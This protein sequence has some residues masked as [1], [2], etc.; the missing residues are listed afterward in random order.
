MEDETDTYSE[1]S[2]SWSSSPS[3]HETK[4][5]CERLFF[6][7]KRKKMRL[8]AQ[9]IS[10]EEIVRQTMSDILDVIGEI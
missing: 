5:S 1:T 2:E 4:R 9:K 3:I 8:K 7:I 10:I 6:A